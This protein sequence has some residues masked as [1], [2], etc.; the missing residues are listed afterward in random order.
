MNIFKTNIIIVI[1]VI[2]N[3]YMN[4]IQ[5]RIFELFHVTFIFEY[6]IHIVY[7]NEIIYVYTYSKHT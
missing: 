6:T 5:Y 7:L 4:L 1:V 3:T 2:K